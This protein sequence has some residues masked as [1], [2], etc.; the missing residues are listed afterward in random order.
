MPFTG[1]FRVIRPSGEIVWLAN[2][3]HCECSPSREVVSVLGTVQDI[4]ARKRSE[5]ALKAYNQ[6]LELIAR[7]RGLA[8]DPGRSCPLGR[9]AA[10]WFTLLVLIL[11]KAT[12]LLRFGAGQS[13]PA[14]YNRAVDGVPVGPK[15]GSCGTAAFR[16]ATVTVTD[17]ASDT[18]WEDYRDLP[19][20]TA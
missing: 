8:Q 15:A 13:L 12:G 9:G 4:T 10:A 18:L 20:G 6:I 7:R 17:I 16:K 14:E 5:W 19:D 11:D 2:V 3:A 1:E